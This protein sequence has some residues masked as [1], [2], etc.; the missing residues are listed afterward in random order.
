MMRI[1]SKPKDPPV[2]LYCVYARKSMEDEESQALSID[3]QLSEMKKIIERDGLKVV[4]IKTESHSAKDSGQ[5]PVFNEM[6]SDIKNEKYNAILTWHANQL[7]RNAGDLGM[8]VD[9]MDKGLLLEVRTFSQTFS[10][11]PNEKF[12]LMI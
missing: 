2:I 11:S 12:M 3:S 6:L 1:H 5:R 10:N 7:S 4:E 8:L 9:L